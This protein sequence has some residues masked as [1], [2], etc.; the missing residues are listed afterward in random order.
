MDF[1]TENLNKIDFKQL[2]YFSFLKDNILNNEILIFSLLIIFLILIALGL[3]NKI[4]IFN[5]GLDFYQ[6]LGIVIIPLLSYIYVQL[7]IQNNSE[8]FIAESNNK[9]NIIYFVS[10][11]ISMI[12][13]LITIYTSVSHNGII[14]G[15]LVSFLKIIIS[16]LLLVLIFSL[17]NQN[18]KK[19]PLYQT[20]FLL[21]VLGWI[22]SKLINGEKVRKKN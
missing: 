16:S 21:G 14:L 17:I 2:N 4:I 11:C 19:R 18:K 3:S 6:T 12:F 8:N 15:L 10:F 9:A 13:I 20:V 1:V 7:I 5:D 22:T